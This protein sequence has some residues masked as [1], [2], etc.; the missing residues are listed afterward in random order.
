MKIACYLQLTLI[1]AFSKKFSVLE[2][3]KFIHFGKF[4]SFEIPSSMVSRADNYIHS[5]WISVNNHKRIGNA[6]R[7]AEKHV[8]ISSTQY[9]TFTE[10]F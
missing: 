6:R 2:L 1:Y 5:I 4:Q 10:T 7:V 3:F 8:V 9:I